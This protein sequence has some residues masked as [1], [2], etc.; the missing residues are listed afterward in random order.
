MHGF[1]GAIACWFD[2]LFEFGIGRFFFFSP[3]TNMINKYVHHFLVQDLNC[4]K[5]WSVLSRDF[6]KRNLFQQYFPSNSLVFTRIEILIKHIQQVD[7]SKWHA[8]FEWILQNVRQT[9]LSTTTMCLYMLIRS[10]LTKSDTNGGYRQFL[11]MGCGQW[12]GRT[13]FGQRIG[14]ECF[15]DYFG[16]VLFLSV[17]PRRQSITYNHPSLS[18]EIETMFTG[19]ADRTTTIVYILFTVEI[20][21]GEKLASN[22]KLC[23]WPLKKIVVIVTFPRLNPLPTYSTSI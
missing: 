19:L 8:A 17:L 22:A 4:C 2:L 13:D 7:G 23:H 18:S 3:R 5:S 16:L 12:T 10:A 14:K 21:V 15:Y 1:T 6:G 20:T 9:C 11:G